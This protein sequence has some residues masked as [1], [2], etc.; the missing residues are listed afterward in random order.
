MNETSET[1][2]ENERK[3][4][5]TTKT[6]SGKK[7]FKE[8]M[9]RWKDTEGRLVRLDDQEELREALREM[10]VDKKPAAGKE[11]R[12]VVVLMPD[13]GKDIGDGFQG[14]GSEYA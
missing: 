10:V 11:R 1:V 13:A 6:Y 3:T 7:I 14:I 9:L 12:E 8:V 4:A 5:K 2:E